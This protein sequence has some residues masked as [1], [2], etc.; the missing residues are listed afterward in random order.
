VGDGGSM[1]E[2]KTDSLDH[3]YL[4]NKLTKLQG[5]HERTEKLMDKLYQENLEA[6]GKRPER[7][8]ATAKNPSPRTEQ[9]KR[10]AF[11]ARRLPPKP[12]TE[13]GFFTLAEA[14]KYLQC[15]SEKTV[16]R[17]IHAGKFENA[18]KV[19]FQGKKRWLIK[20]VDLNRYRHIEDNWLWRQTGSVPTLDGAKAQQ[21]GH[22][23]VYGN[24]P[25][26]AP[27]YLLT[28][29]IEEFWR[30]VCRR[31]KTQDD[32]EAVKAEIRARLPGG[33]PTNFRVRYQFNRKETDRF[34]TRM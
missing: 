24:P 30:F 22:V 32:Y 27:I 3:P 26:H 10:K 33:K 16:V 13:P 23:F 21:L 2:P 28:V 20:R 17:L 34:L 4:A 1:S 5:V 19:V 12:K 6:E 14:A 25:I 7:L 9:E 31:R 8:R 15:K 18:K 29:S 11:R